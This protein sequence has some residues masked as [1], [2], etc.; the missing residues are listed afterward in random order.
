MNTLRQEVLTET[1]IDLQKMVYM[2]T[3]KIAL[4][5]GVPFEDL[6]GVS[7]QI[8]VKE[9][10]RYDSKH[11]ASISSW[12]YSKVNWGL[13]SFMRKEYRHLH[14][15]NLDDA[16]EQTC[17]PN[18]FLA[19]IKSELSEDANSI[20]AL[21]LD[22]HND[23]ALLCKWRKTRTRRAALNALV[24]HLEDVGWTEE[25]IELHFNEIRKALI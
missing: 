3:N 6:I 19:E 13:L 14:L 15:G 7:H 5:Y 18:T 2:V 11:G 22:T 16:P 9:C 1:Y 25:K 23:F 21:V 8:F 17:P 12:I 20:V 24:E 10:D 4:R